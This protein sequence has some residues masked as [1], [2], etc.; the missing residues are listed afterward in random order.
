[1]ALNF[2]DQGSVDLGRSRVQ[3][4]DPYQPMRNIPNDG[5][6]MEQLAQSLSKFAGVAKANEEKDIEAEKK[7][8]AVYSQML[9]DAIKDGPVTDQAVNDVLSKQHILT[10]AGAAE[11]FGI[12]RGVVAAQNAFAQFPTVMEPEKAQEAYDKIMSQARKDSEGNLSY[13]QGYLKAFEQ[14]Y[15]RRVEKDGED[16]I[17]G[18]KDSSIEAYKIRQRGMIQD[19]LDG[20]GVY[21]D[22]GVDSKVIETPAAKRILELDPSKYDTPYK[23]ATQLVGADEKVDTSAISSFIRRATGKKIDPSQTPWCAAFVEGVLASKGQSGTGSWMARSY[24]N[25]GEG[26]SDPKQGDL[27]VLKRGSDPNKGH[28]GFF[29]G[30]DENGNVKVLGGNQGNKVSVSSF[31][32][33]D[34]LGFRKID[35]GDMKSHVEDNRPQYASLNAGTATDA[36][37]GPAPAGVQVAD[38]GTKPNTAYDGSPLTPKLM[39]IQQEAMRLD[40]IYKATRLNDN[41]ERRDALAEEIRLEA[42][43]RN[44]PSILR[45]FPKEIMTDEVRRNYIATEKEIQRNIEHKQQ[46]AITRTEHAEKTAKAETESR[47]TEK[48]AKGERIDEFKDTQY[49]YFDHVTGKQVTRSNHTLVAIADGL[50]KKDR[51]DSL[52]SKGTAATLNEKFTAGYVKNDLREAF[53]DDPAMLALLGDR[54]MLTDQEARAY[55]ANRTDLNRDEKLKLWENMD[56]WKNNYA[57]VKDQVVQDFYKHYVGNTVDKYTKADKV[58]LKMA[59]VDI[60]VRNALASVEGDVRQA[61]EDTVLHDINGFK[62][63]N[64]RDP[65]Y[66]EKKKILEDAAKKAREVFDDRVKIIEGIEPPPPGGNNGQQTSQPLSTQNVEVTTNPDG[67]IVINRK[68]GS[69]QSTSQPAKPE[70]KPAAMLGAP[71][72]G[73]QTMENFISGIGNLFTLN[74]S[75]R[76]AIPMLQQ[77]AVKELANDP[78]YKQLVDKYN[79]TPQGQRGAVY[80]EISKYYGTFVENYVTEHLQ[81]ITPKSNYDPT[82]V[83]KK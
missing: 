25:Y 1:M 56:S 4:P 53:A 43:D 32:A 74:S 45:A 35:Q 15:I 12:R 51:V 24:L 11:D 50:N 65:T 55:I 2:Q 61:F 33:D 68:Q 47:I 83:R 7:N 71:A 57:V 23:L 49:T 5:T 16:R 64:K 69:P 38:A 59:S 75:Q 72:G 81:G 31:S 22:T 78:T 14:H 21:K 77:S 28:V 80:G 60:N 82:S 9:A 70:G 8:I 63:D 27:V 39:R 48:A 52:D 67:S 10:R 34:V 3:T 20:S 29:A 40:G 19:V 6:Q 41:K 17:K 76:D 42:L 54:K 26:T 37:T 79:S 58:A 73:V 36:S 44:D 66:A 13:Q 30:Y 46:Q 18:Y 62:A